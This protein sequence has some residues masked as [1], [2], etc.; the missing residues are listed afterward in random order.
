VNLVVNARDA[1]AD[2]G[3]LRIETTSYEADDNDARRNGINRGE[4]VRLVVSDTG[5]GM[6]QEVVARAFEPFFTT[7]A[8]GQ[9][10]GLGLATVYGIVSQA[11]GNVVIRSQ[12]EL[13][14]S[15][16]VSLPA[17]HDALPADSEMPPGR[18]LASNGETILLVEDE[19]MV[20]EPTRRILISNGYAVLAASSA[21]E[22]LR[23]AGEHAGEIGLLLTDVVMPSRSG[24]DLAA[25]LSRTNPGI[26][27]LFM[28]G[29]TSGPIGFRTTS[30]QG[31]NLIEKPFAAEGLLRRV[32]EVLT[33]E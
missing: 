13:G 5:H 12:P 31:V 22:A 15:V 20:R 7:K 4:Y 3:T 9:G 30:E 17:T 33:D 11:G 26:K 19:E 29:Y 27:V 6:A 18:P 24:K 21:E 8:K 32:R 10:T 16:E 1:M 25:D 2:G 14:T 28:S 23:I